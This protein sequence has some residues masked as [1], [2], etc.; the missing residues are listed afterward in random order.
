MISPVPSFLL[1]ADNS[2]TG[3]KE[4]FWIGWELVGDTE[5]AFHEGDAGIM[6]VQEPVYDETSPNSSNI[7]MKHENSDSEHSDADHHDNDEKKDDEHKDEDH[8]KDDEH[9]DEGEHYKGSPDEEDHQRRRKRPHAPGHESDL[10]V[11]APQLL[12]LDLSGKPLWFNGWLY[13][14]K[15]AGR[16]KQ[17]GRFE[18]YMKEPREVLEPGAWQ[19][20]EGN[21]CC[22][23]N[24]E[25][26]E[27]SS[28]EK[29]K[30]E[31]MIGYAREAGS[32]VDRK[33]GKKD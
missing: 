11:C 17:G 21:V 31:M 27:F 19:L 13:H 25:V 20:E 10:T 14:N 3:D 30:L 28:E 18:V 15:F 7:K 26:F 9:K 1:S 32:Y 16:E 4:T 8:H 5:Y 29:G 2:A 22:L 24:K 12:H 23:S 33:G 6:G